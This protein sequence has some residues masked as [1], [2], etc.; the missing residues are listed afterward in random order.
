MK[1]LGSA[2]ILV[3]LGMAVAVPSRAADAPRELL[4][5]GWDEVFILKIADAAVAPEKVWRWKALD[6][7]EIPEH[8]R[9][10]FKTTAECKAVAG[11][12]ILIV[13]SSGGIA[14]VERASGKAVF[15]ATCGNTHSAELLPGD[16]IAAA[17]SVHANGNRLAVFDIR[18]PEREVFSTE[19]YSGHGA[20]WD[21]QRKLLWALGG[22]E[23]RAY[24]L[25]AW[26]SNAPSLKLEAKYPLPSRGGHDL[27][28]IDRRRLGVTA[29]RQSWI[30]DRDKREFAPHP[31]L[32]EA[33]DVKS[34]SV[35]PGSGRVAYTQADAPEWW[36]RTIRFLN[37]AGSVKLDAERMYKVRWIK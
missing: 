21:E 34:M 1:W 20:L 36:T 22:P 4:V 29:V 24:S 23:L 14:L 16:R 28:E 2:V 6:R 33:H 31:Q 25:A 30:F 35:H 11:N 27:V 32:G 18:T 19:L 15:W 10:T 5:C 9:T 8:I 7:P 26:E 13:A 3:V 12:R 17:C 37:P